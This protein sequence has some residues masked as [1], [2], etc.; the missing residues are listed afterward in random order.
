MLNRP[1]FKLPLLKSVQLV[2]IALVILNICGTLPYDQSFN[3]LYSASNPIPG[4]HFRRTPIDLAMNHANELINSNLSDPQRAGRLF[5]L[6]SDSFLHQEPSAIKISDNWILWV[7]G[8]WDRNYRTEIQDTDFL[9]K[10]ASGFCR[11]AAMLYADWASRLGL[12]ARVVLLTGHV[13]AEV[14]L[15][16]FGWLTVDPDLGVFW[17]Y[18]VDQFGDQLPRSEIIATLTNKGYSTTYSEE[19]AEILISQSDNSYALFPLNQRRYRIEVLSKYLKWIFP[20]ILFL[21]SFIGGRV[22]DRK[23]LLSSN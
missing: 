21:L 9:W 22:G 12:K 13:V 17:R 3:N 14:Y 6:I 15:P 18:P 20:V 19:I 16:N 7:L 10:R 5:E 8:I 1:L 23:R 2:C 11:Q 4:R